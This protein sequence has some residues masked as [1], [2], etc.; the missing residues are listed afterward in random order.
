MVKEGE[1]STA[2]FKTI[3]LTGGRLPDG[4]P[5]EVLFFRD[6]QIY[7]ELLTLS[8]VSDPLNSRANE[9]DPTLDQIT[10]NLSAAYELLAV[11]NR[12]IQKQQILQ[13]IAALEFIEEEYEELA[14]LEKLEEQQ[15]FENRNAIASTT[16]SPTSKPTVSP[17]APTALNKLPDDE[18]N[19]ANLENSPRELAEGS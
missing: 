14:M 5:I 10:I 1:L 12:Q 15:E 13:S 8:G 18:D 16:S 9:P 4:T 7:V 11:E 17:E 6:E 3:E 2:Q 19:M